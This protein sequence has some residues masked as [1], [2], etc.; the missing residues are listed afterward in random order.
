[1]DW[2]DITVI[3]VL[4]AGIIL[5]VFRKTFKN[6]PILLGA[7]IGGVF[8]LLA[9]LL[10]IYPILRLTSPLWWTLFFDAPQFHFIGNVLFYAILGAILGL[11]VSKLRHPK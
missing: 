9:N 11:I 6:N 8:G 7:F 10:L 1:M 2:S 4:V 5:V 3:I